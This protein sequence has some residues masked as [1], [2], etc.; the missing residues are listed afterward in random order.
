MLV[1]ELG[2]YVPI[3]LYLKNPRNEFRIAVGIS[4]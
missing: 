4:Q 3:G 1:P 2:L